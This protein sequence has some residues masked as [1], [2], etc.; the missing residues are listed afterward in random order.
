MTK[1]LVSGYIGFNNFGDEAIFKVLSNHLK[2]LGFDVSVLCNNKKLVRKT[3]NVKTYNYKKPLQIIKAILSCDILISG[4][5]SLLQNKTSNKSLVYYLL[6]IF[7]S[8]LFLK[9]VLI[10]A[11][12]IEPVNGAFFEFLLKTILKRADY[13][14]V[15]DQKSVDYLNK[16]K[17]NSTLNSDPVYS[18]VESVDIEKEKT[19]LV[20]QL[21]DSKNLSQDFLDNLALSISRYYRKKVS[22]FCFEKEIDEKGQDGD[23]R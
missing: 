2:T 3:Y 4:G 8:K 20:V 7:L 21:R 1:V 10:F 9:K 11:Q 6:I 19:G 12:G 14:C 5:G 22:V 16:L 13:I 15:R 17:I 23:E 18:L